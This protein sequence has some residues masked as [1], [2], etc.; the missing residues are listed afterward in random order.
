MD[1]KKENGK[2]VFDSLPIYKNRFPSPKNE[3][4]EAPLTK[5]S[6]KVI[7]SLEIYP[8]GDDMDIT[9][10]SIKIFYFDVPSE[11]RFR[12]D[13]K[14]LIENKGWFGKE[15]KKYWVIEVHKIN[16]LYDTGVLTDRHSEGTFLSNEIE[17]I[18]YNNYNLKNN[19][20]KKEA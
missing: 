15:T 5:C 20:Y 7:D 3:Y 11:E 1:L 14:Y 16:S 6:S 2:Y 17:K 8:Y 10:A 19:Y 13:F 18:F 4:F 9:K 12:I